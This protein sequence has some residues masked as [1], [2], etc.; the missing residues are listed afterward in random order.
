MNTALGLSTLLNLGQA[1]AETAGLVS[2]YQTGIEKAV[3]FLSQPDK[4]IE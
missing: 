3:R 1:V 4:L 2:R